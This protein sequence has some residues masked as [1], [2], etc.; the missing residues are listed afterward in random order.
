MRLKLAV[1]R[2]CGAA[3]QA[4][5]L[6]VG[7]APALVSCI[8]FDAYLGDAGPEVDAGN[9]DPGIDAGSEPDAGA[10]AGADAG[11]VDASGALPAPRLVSPW[12]GAYTGSARAPGSRLPTFRWQGVR[13]ASHFEIQIGAACA[14]APPSACEPTEIEVDVVERTTEH[15]LA[16]PLPV[17]DLSD[18]S[19]LGRRYYWRV[20]ACADACSAWSS[21][22][23]V[24]VGRL[25]DDVD[26][27]GYADLAIG[28]EGSRERPRP[29][30][31]FV[32]R[33]R[34]DLALAVVELAPPPAEA[35]DL[36]GA[37]VAF[38]DVDADGLAEILVTSSTHLHVYAGSRGLG[39]PVPISESFEVRAPGGGGLRV[40]RAGDLDADGFQDVVV[41]AP[42]HDMASGRLYVFRGAE[43]GLRG[44]IV[45]DNDDGTAAPGDR[46]GW[47]VA[48]AGDLDGDG[49]A[50]LA[51]SAFT[52]EESVG[53]VRVLYGQAEL[54]AP[55]RRDRLTPTTVITGGVLFGV[56]VTGGVDLSGDGYADLAVGGIGSNDE[57]AG[58]VQVHFGHPDGVRE[59]AIHTLE[60]RGNDF[61][62]SLALG[63]LDANGEIDLVVGAENAPDRADPLGDVS[64][65]SGP[66]FATALPNHLLMGISEREAA[67]GHAVVLKDLDGDGVAELVVSAHKA[68]PRD[69]GAVF[70][71]PGPSSVPE[72]VDV[73][74][75][76]DDQKLGS[77]LG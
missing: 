22:R 43:D 55:L 75:L 42:D 24:E 68:T 10:D 73:G 48:G 14:G 39:A 35:P 44:P 4:L 41:G 15:T 19:G 72:T 18:T 25:P 77:S 57:C 52:D 5:V 70:V 63:D 76:A 28:A 64:W 74:D 62:R 23:Y 54:D 47:A 6:V 13:G 49:F 69:H 2:S 66:G 45:I 29:G 3:T 60:C 31:A 40:A 27:D 7:L 11:G 8:D 26:G 30:R 46:L 61:G 36:F 71:Y 51:A 53:S 20:R 33:G 50:D 32:A 56:S 1:S 9:P 38:A 58:L 59:S 65:F 34:S 16:E 17:D 67:F 21:T 12:N 37:S